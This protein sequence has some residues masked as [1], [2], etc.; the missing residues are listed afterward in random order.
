MDTT[1]AAGASLSAPFPSASRR[2]FIRPAARIAAA[3]LS[4]AVAVSG[5]TGSAGDEHPGAA[6]V[7]GG[8][9]GRFYGQTIDWRD[10][11]DGGARCGTFEVPLDYAEPGGERLDIAVRR[12]PATGPAPIGSL[13]VNP[14]GPGGSGVEYADSAAR[15][16]GETVRER[17]DIVGFDPRGVDRSSPI[18]CLDRS[19]MD[20]FIAVDFTGPGGGS[21]PA[22]VGEA[23]LGELARLNRGFVEG[24]REDSGGLMMHMG[25]DEVARDVDVLRS[26]LDDDRLTFLGK[27]YGTYVGAHYADRFPD[28]VRALV[29]DGA[30]HPSA[31]IVELGMRQAEGAEVA[32]RSFVKA[33]LE[34]EDCPLGG[35][36]DGV[37]SATERLAGLLERA[38]REPLRSDLDDGRTAGRSWLE[39]GIHS[40]LYSESSWPQ[41]STALS[42]AFDGDGTRLLR[43]AGDL[44]NRG[45]TAEYTNY[46]SALVAVNCSDRQS[47]R[48]IGA[49]D[50]AAER[51]DKTAPLFGAP[52]TWGGLTCAYWP[53][54]AVAEPEPLDAPGAPPILVVGTTRDS[55]TPYEWARQMAGELES[56]VLLTREGDG[57]TAYGRGSDCVDSAVDTYLLR[58][59]PPEKGTV[60]S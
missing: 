34:V 19:E 36:G 43:M 8:A 40:A 60:C 47:P 55:A 10:C 16:V 1:S 53:E 17:F 59:E 52:L 50:E 13:V 28:R 4:L 45:D 58:G 23:G 14:G 31:G 22:D 5:C 57:H 6:D 2:P 15:T 29:L 9:P 32:L 27:S 54:E 24:C 12:I 18:A 20:D 26:A 11:G 35:P 42:E 48:D 39:L 21:D 46:T 37:A 7:P 38:G 30:L 56:G 3:V 44:Y 51:A 25:T 33:C 41:L 49:F